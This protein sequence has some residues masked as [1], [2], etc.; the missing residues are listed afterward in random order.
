[1]NVC[2]RMGIL[3]KPYITPNGKQISI[4]NPCIPR[5]ASILG[6]ESGSS[7]SDSL[8]RTNSNESTI[9]PNEADDCREA[10]S[11]RP[12]KPRVEITYIDK[13]SGKGSTIIPKLDMKRIQPYKCPY[14]LNSSLS[15]DNVFSYTNKNDNVLAVIRRNIHH[16]TLVIEGKKT[17]TISC[18]RVYNDVYMVVCHDDDITRWRM[19]MNVYGG[20]YMLYDESKD[21]I[22]KLD[23]DSTYVYDIGEML[24]VTFSVFNKIDMVYSDMVHEMESIINMSNT[25]RARNYDNGEQPSETYDVVN[26]SSGSRIRIRPTDIPSYRLISQYVSNSPRIPKKSSKTM[27]RQNMRTFLGRK[28]RITKV[29]QKALTAPEI[30]PGKWRTRLSKMVSLI[31]ILPAKKRHE[32]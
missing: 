14:A 10:G 13:N 25:S 30:A 17:I 15:S 11:V 3:Y 12:K 20:I 19:L 18:N 28:K 7:S 6:S 1:M 9:E 4:P 23:A 5:S 8:R 27:G 2:E 22:A 32:G 26:S 24:P 21:M 16:F 31:P 29:E